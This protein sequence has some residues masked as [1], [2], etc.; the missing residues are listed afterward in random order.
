MSSLLKKERHEISLWLKRSLHRLKWKHKR[1]TLTYEIMQG[2]SLLSDEDLEKVSQSGWLVTPTSLLPSVLVELGMEQIVNQEGSW[3]KIISDLLQVFNITF[4]IRLFFQ[5]F[6]EKIL[7]LLIIMLRYCPQLS[8]LM[9]S[10]FHGIPD[11][12]SHTIS[13]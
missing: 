3:I 2:W 11:T 12:S 7:I 6:W 5:T 1:W 8:E 4:V 9:F 10:Y 13:C